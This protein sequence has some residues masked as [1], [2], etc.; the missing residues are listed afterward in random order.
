MDID[1]YGSMLIPKQKGRNCNYLEKDG[2]A[3]IVHNFFAWLTFSLNATQINVAKEWCRF[4]QINVFHEYFPHWVNVQFLSSQFYIVHTDKN[5][6]F[7]RLTIKHSQFGTFSQP[8]S[9]NNF[10]ELPFP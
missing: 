9:N 7:S 4:S 5:S 8:W 2:T 3:Q 10:L 6:S 1:K